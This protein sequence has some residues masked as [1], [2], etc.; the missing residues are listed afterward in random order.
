MQASCS[1]MARLVFL[2]LQPRLY[3]CSKETTMA[4]ST[5]PELT[6]YMFAS[7][8]CRLT[9]TNVATETLTLAIIAG[10]KQ[11][12]GNTY[13]PNSDKTVTVY[14]LDRFVE[15]LIDDIFIDLTFVINGEPEP[16]KV[17]ACSASV[18]EPAQTFV[19]D[20]FLTP[21]MGERNTAI[22]R[23]EL[24]TAFCPTEE[25]VDV[26]CTFLLDD[27]TI[28]TRPDGLGVLSGWAPF[29]VSPARFSGGEGRL[30]AYTVTC[31][32][33]KARYRVLGYAPS[34]DPV[35][36]YRNCFHTWE[37]IHLTGKKESSASYTRS[38][39]IIE[40]CTRNYEIQETM[41]HKAMTGPLRPGT[42]AMVLDLARSKEVLLLNADGTPGDEVTITDC[43]TKMTNEDNE[44]PD[45]T[46]TY[47]L[48]DRRNVRVNAV[49]LPRI[50]DKHF[51]EHFV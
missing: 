5:T 36:L 18:S 10:G 38:Q 12:F 8:L 29:D 45:F 48:A 31:G 7:E 19:S 15:A 51:D 46:I 40:G 23:I 25:K 26:Q 43:D 9:F 30:I 49:R 11:V 39:A 4:I 27:G 37:T 47:R 6:E 44:I 13:F 22:G 50:F 20:F 32:K 24:L 2:P 28:E 14:D 1:V 16:V 21:V 3:L 35:M 41:S 33:R 17:F 42:E 34:A